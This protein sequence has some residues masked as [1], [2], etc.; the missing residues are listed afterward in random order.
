MILPNNGKVIIIDDEPKDVVDLTE[1]LTKEKMPFL[2]FKDPG[3]ED[4]PDTP[5]NNVRLLFLDLELGLGGNSPIEKIRIVQQRIVRVIEPHT[6]YVLII[7]SSHEDVYLQ[8]LLEEFKNGFIKYAPIAH[9]SL[10]KAEIKKK[11]DADVNVLLIIR[12]KLKQEL[13]RFNSF[14]LF[15]LWESIINDSCGEAVNNIINSIYIESENVDLELRTIIRKLANAYLGQRVLKADN[16]TIQRASMYTF[17]DLFKE[18]IEREI[19]KSNLIDDLDFSNVNPGNI[20]LVSKLNSK[21]LLETDV[22]PDRSPGNV[23]LLEK[24]EGEKLSKEIKQ[25]TKQT[26]LENIIIKKEIKDSIKCRV[27]TT[28]KRVLGEKELN[29]QVNQLIASILAQSVLVEIEISPVCDFAQNKR[30][31]SRSIK[32][33]LFPYG[34]IEEKAIKSKTDYLFISPLFEFDNKMYKLIVDLRLFSSTYFIENDLFQPLFKI[35]HQLLSEI[36]LSV[37]KHVSRTGLS[38]LDE[39]DF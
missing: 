23:Y 21:L 16:K 6:P 4:L 35:R 18:S 36:Q 9:C 2:F 15:L 5:I 1:A 33:C 24:E 34:I 20:S 8:T 28:E 27:E 3:L 13:S 19:I 37:S 26:W 11:K 29:I 12:Q 22:S 7:W 38:F 32:G 25:K 30:I 10:D 39:R 14:N 31:L 17:N